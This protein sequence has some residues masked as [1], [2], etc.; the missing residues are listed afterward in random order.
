MADS[1]VLSTQK[2][3]KFLP[4][5][6]L[7]SNRRKEESGFLAVSAVYHRRS[8]IREASLTRPLPW[9]KCAI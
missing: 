6:E 8:M 9:Q 5:I 1:D 4:E 2:A 7:G 3:P